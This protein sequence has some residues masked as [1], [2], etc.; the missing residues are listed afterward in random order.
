MHLFIHSGVQATTH[1]GEGGLLRKLLR[2]TKRL[3]ARILRTNIPYYFLW[4]ELGQ[5]TISIIVVIT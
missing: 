4:D 3:E 5:G 2:H 1:Q